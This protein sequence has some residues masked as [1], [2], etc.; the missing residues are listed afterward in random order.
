MDPDVGVVVEVSDRFREMLKDRKSSM[1][2]AQGLRARVEWS[3]L[4]R[5]SAEILKMCGWNMN[6]PKVPFEIDQLIE[7]EGYM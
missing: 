4:R 3:D 6:L 2:S 7:V 5:L 1:W